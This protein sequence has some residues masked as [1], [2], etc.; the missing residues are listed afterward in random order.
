MSPRRLIFLVPAALAT[1]VL[2]ACGIG[3]DGPRVAQTRDVA[4]FTRIDSG[5]SVDVRVRVGEAQRVQVS[6]GEEVI[7]DVRTSVRDGVLHVTFDHRGFGG[8]D[9]VVDASVPRL[10]GIDVSGSGDVDALGVDAEEFEVRSDGSADV[11]VQGTARTLAV[12]LDG[13][14]DADLTD[15][16]SREAQVTVGGSGDADVRVDERLRATVDGSGDLHYRGDP[17][18][19]RH[20]DGSGEIDRAD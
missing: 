6:A 9:V 7:D 8:G 4:R 17:E 10:T 11:S 1:L 14:G 18:L 2:G 12:E 19:T 16:V 15:L 3:D 13:S 5:D 20:V